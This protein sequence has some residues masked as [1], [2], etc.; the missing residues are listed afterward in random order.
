[1]YA[2]QCVRLLSPAQ[3]EAAVHILTVKVS[4]VRVEPQLAPGRFS[5]HVASQLEVNDATEHEP[6]NP[7]SRTSVPQQT[8][9]GPHPPGPVLPGQSNA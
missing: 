4:G 3:S 1:L 8:V 6:T 5:V 9:P 2:Q 7:P